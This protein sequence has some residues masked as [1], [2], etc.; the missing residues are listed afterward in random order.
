MVTAATGET[1]FESAR[2]AAL[3]T[4]AWAIEQALPLWS[5]AGFDE[6]WGGFH[7]RLSYDG[8]PIANAPRRLMVQARQIYV[9]AH[10]DLLGWWPDRDGRIAQAVDTMVSKFLRIDGKPGFVHS[11]T[12]DGAIANPARDA[13]AYA[14]VL[15]GLAWALRRGPDTRVL[16]LVDETV[17]DLD[18]QF[19]ASRG[20]YLTENPARAP[21]RLQNP[22][23]H[24][25]E[26][27]L[28]LYESTHDARFL[29]RA[30]EIFGLFTTRFLAHQPAI[31]A[32]YFDAEWQ[33]APGQRGRLWEPGHQFEWA[34]LLRC[35]GRL[36]G[37][38]TTHYA[39]LL[40]ERAWADGRDASGL[41]VD[42]CDAAGGHT[43]G[44]RRC[45]PQTEALKSLAIETE[46]SDASVATACANNV[47]CTVKGL[48]RAFL[49]APTHGGWIDHIDADGQKIVE[50][51][52]A[53]TLYH[54]FLAIAEINRVFDPARP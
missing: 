53:S 48:E 1:P 8:K 28:A 37:R 33:P 22:H 3:R 42:E 38:D 46:C 11:V 10:A 35:F 34:W 43:K 2:L 20:G 6:R 50:T 21:E 31:L 14:F 30:G 26:A 52:P 39:R 51:M 45:W 7:E 44:S 13:Y 25:I 16:A 27:F 9:Y 24:L 5:S 18:A 36:S 19:S 23:M 47:T 12:A 17:A 40:H 4:K 49:T 54:V 32:E 15:F 29:A 41:V